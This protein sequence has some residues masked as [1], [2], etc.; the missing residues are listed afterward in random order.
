MFYLERH[1]TCK[2]GLG[3]YLGVRQQLLKQLKGEFATAPAGVLIACQMLPC[4]CGTHQLDS[5]RLNCFQAGRTFLFGAE[6]N[7]SD[8]LQIS[9][10]KRIAK[11]RLVQAT[12]WRQ[13]DYRGIS[14][15]AASSHFGKITNNNNN[16]NRFIVETPINTASWHLHC[17]D[18][19]L[20]FF[21]DFYEQL[22]LELQ[23]DTQ[24][25]FPPLFSFLSVLSLRLRRI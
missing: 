24:L 7:A 8:P 16:N 13:S 14:P 19:W 6:F 1:I 4:A 2:M 10:V 21:V 20:D 3:V 22:Q 25:N 11:W 17:I 15:V 12:R 9:M 18:C 5:T 23:L